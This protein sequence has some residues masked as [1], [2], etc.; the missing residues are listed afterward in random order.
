MAEII[1]NRPF[2]YYSITRR[3]FGS[4]GWFSHMCLE[5]CRSAAVELQSTEHRE[6][7]RRIQC[8]PSLGHPFPDVGTLLGRGGESPTQRIAHTS[9]LLVGGRQ[10]P[11]RT[12]SPH[13]VAAQTVSVTFGRK[14]GMCSQ[15]PMKRTRS[16]RAVR[17]ERAICR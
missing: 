15:V 1:P 8:G 5:R 13:T 16:R 14:P 12:G 10:H 4:F 6:R 17:A 11:E 7:T 2:G 9:P 3:P